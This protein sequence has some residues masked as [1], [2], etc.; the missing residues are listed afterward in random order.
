M[1]RKLVH[2][3]Y[4]FAIRG[5]FYNIG[6]GSYISF[7]ASINAPGSI[8]IGLN[9]TIR[10]LSW[11]NALTQKSGKPSLVIGDNVMVGRFAHINA[12]E[13]VTLEDYVLL[14]DRVHISDVN[15]ESSD[16]QIPIMLQGVTEP[17][18]V[19]LKRGCWIGI[20]ATILPGVTIGK[21]AVV[22]A[23]A[24]VTKDVPD[25]MIARGV[26]AKN[27]SKKTENIQTLRGRVS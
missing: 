3:S 5:S 10:T 7:P 27:Y 18:P 13:S 9:S 2:R 19:L 8:A 20:G 17:R 22:A 16:A 14:A 25:N 11:L 12:Y 21:N 6:S 15:H 4:T 24:V 1:L 26:P 23:H